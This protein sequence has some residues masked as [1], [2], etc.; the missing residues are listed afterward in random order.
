MESN[1]GMDHSKNEG[2][3][4]SKNE[5]TRSKNEGTEEGTESR[6]EAMDYRDEGGVVLVVENSSS[7][8]EG[9][10]ISEE[11]LK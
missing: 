9:T 6:S 2:M 4:D 8:L 3:E 1:E 7:T 5:R 10:C 11:P